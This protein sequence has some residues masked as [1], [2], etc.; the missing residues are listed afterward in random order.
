MSTPAFPVAAAGAVRGVDDVATEVWS[1]TEMS[2]PNAK[3]AT[4]PNRIIVSSVRSRGRSL[5]RGPVEG[6][7]PAAP[8]PR[9]D[10]PRRATRPRRSLSLPHVGL[11]QVL[12]AILFVALVVLVAILL[13][14]PQGDA[15][16]LGTTSSPSNATGAVIPT[17]TPSPTLPSPTVSAAAARTPA[18]AVTPIPRSTATPAATPRKTQRPQPAVTPA[19]TPRKSIAPSA[20]AAS[21]SATPGGAV[22]RSTSGTPTPAPSHPTP[23][24]APSTAPDA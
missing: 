20:T 13:F 12:T 19:A 7:V 16:V 15:A 2:D 4:Q 3:P 14:R 22:T 1:Q 11:L 21:P 9:V 23:V 18:P 10:Q 6:P 5:R 8:R 17:A 24:P